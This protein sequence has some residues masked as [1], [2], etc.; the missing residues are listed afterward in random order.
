M[1][2]DAG[3]HARRRDESQRG[4]GE[5]LERRERASRRRRTHKNRFDRALMPITS[6]GSERSS[7][8]CTSTGG[9][10][11]RKIRH[12]L[13]TCDSDA[14]FGCGGRA[15]ARARPDE[16]SAFQ[17]ERENNLLAEGLKQ[18]MFPIRQV[19]AL[20]HPWPLGPASSPRL[21]P[22]FQHTVRRSHANPIFQFGRCDAH[23]WPRH[24]EVGAGGGV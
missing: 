16:A 5:E 3:S 9:R 13:K 7:S 10:P 14:G 11:K 21:P 19:V 8:L 4:C 24:L 1:R 18:L 22:R 20:E 15:K 6:D 17:H 23:S 2:E 12:S